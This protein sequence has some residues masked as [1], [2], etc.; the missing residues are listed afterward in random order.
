MSKANERATSERAARRITLGADS[1]RVSAYTRY[2]ETRIAQTLETL[3]KLGARRIIEVG[4]H[5]WAMTLALIESGVFEVVASVSAEEVTRWPDD[6]GVAVR[7]KVV[8]TS[9]GVMASFPHYLANIER[10]LF[11]ID[12][13]ADT[14]IACEIVEHLI[15]S[16]HVLLLNANAWLPSGG[17]LFITT[18]NGA[19]PR[20]PFRRTSP[21]PHLRCFAYERHAYLYTLR[22]L[23]DLV[24]LCGFEIVD[25]GYW[26]PYT[27]TGMRRVYGLLARSGVAYLKERCAS[28]VYVV[29]R[30]QQ[31][32]G[33]LRRVPIAYDVRGDWEYID[34]PQ[35][36]HYVSVQQ[37]ERQDR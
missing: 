8:T 29:A 35:H 7:P 14:V 2:H 18:P 13:A 20:N 30:K 26:D 28:T 17:L 27:R 36:S 6:I 23:T 11:S 1:E 32:V 21:S 31:S 25:A 5:P 12:V 34:G 9:C 10:T 4:G 15:R 24:G 3:S 33:R 19:Q 22:T 16:P 37:T